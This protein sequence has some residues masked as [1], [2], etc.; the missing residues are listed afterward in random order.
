M[1]FPWKAEYSVGIQ[2][3]DQQHRHFLEIADY[4]HRR[5]RSFFV[6]KKEVGS[7]IAELTEYILNHLAT[8]EKYFKEFNYESFD[9]ENDRLHVKAHD[10][11]RQDME[12]YLTKVKD[13]GTN[14]KKLARDI[15]DFTGGWLI[16][17]ILTMDKKYAPFLLSRG[18]K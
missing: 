4:A 7:V 16:G 10:I 2:V 6:S 1:R 11:F 14:I 9:P 3:I 8:E 17:H 12:Q 13:P 15:S 5:S 18:L